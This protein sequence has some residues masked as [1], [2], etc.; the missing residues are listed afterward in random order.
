MIKK[1]KKGLFLS[2]ELLVVV[3]IV[4]GL[5]L[6]ATAAVRTL[7]EQYK[8]NQIIQEIRS[9]SEAI[10]NFTQQYGKA[11]GFVTLTESSGEM[12]DSKTDITTMNT[13]VT[14]AS[15][16]SGIWT[17]KESR[18]ILAFRQ[19]ISSGIMSSS[20]LS[21]YKVPL[22]GY[23]SG[24]F[25]NFDDA[26]KIYAVRTSSA[27]TT[28]LGKNGFWGA[29]VGMSARFLDALTP[30]SK[31]NS[32]AAWILFSPQN[33]LGNSGSY[34]YLPSTNVYADAAGAFTSKFEQDMYY[35]AALNNLA[36]WGTT[37][38]LVS[39]RAMTSP[40]TYIGGA[41]KVPTSSSAS[42]PA[43]NYTPEAGAI[44]PRMGYS[45]DLKIDDGSPATGKIFANDVGMISGGRG[46]L[47]YYN[48]T[49]GA[50]VAKIEF[51]Q[52]D[53]T[54]YTQYHSGVPSITIQN[55]QKAYK[56]QTNAVYSAKTGCIM[57]FVI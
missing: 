11:P 23:E 44:S 26:T 27:V 38:R 53:N 16:N 17:I 2:V 55:L 4:T 47:N 49:T 3:I 19:L 12:A 1:N 31:I 39:H 14:T 57:T 24:S 43:N 28:D 9:Y 20:I 25:A 15:A 29:Y 10:T 33:N 35:L 37:L 50:S 54:I 21:R 48:A 13:Y 6:G 45:I 7:Y 22:N 34:V 30:R 51:D 41:S 5:M 36:P 56:Y 32:N 40:I 42:V 8:I 18:N 52:I 46:C